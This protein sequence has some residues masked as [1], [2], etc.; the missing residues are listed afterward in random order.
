MGENNELLTSWLAWLRL[1]RSDP[2]RYDAL[3]AEEL[4]KGDLSVKQRAVLHGVR[5]RVDLEFDRVEEAIGRLKGVLGRL[6]SRGGVVLAELSALLAN[7]LTMADRCDEALEVLDRAATDPAA[8]AVGVLQLQRAAVY[9]RIGPMRSA[10]ACVDEALDVIGRSDP[11]LRARALNNRGIIRLYV[12]DLAA[13]RADFDEAEAIYRSDGQHAAAAEVAHN[14]AMVDAREGDLVAALAGFERAERELRTLGVPADAQAI[15]RAEILQAVGFYEEVLEELPA[16]VARLRATG[17]MADADEG[18]VYLAQAMY[19]TGQPEAATFLATTANALRRSNRGGWAAVLDDLALDIRLTSGETTG[20]VVAEAERIAVM[21]DHVGMNMFATRSWLRVAELALRVGDEATGRRAL[22]VVVG[23]TDS[24]VQRVLSFEARA[25]VSVLDGDVAAARSFT[26]QGLR[27]VD[28]LRSVM[29]ATDLRVQASAWGDGLA[30]LAVAIEADHGD[31]RDLLAAAERWRA[32]AAFVRPARRDDD[33]EIAGLLGELRSAN[34][35]VAIATAADREAARARVRAAEAAVTRATRIRSGGR[36]DDFGVRVEG[37]LASLTPGQMF[38]EFIEDRG[39]VSA[40]V[41][42]D[43]E[44]AVRQVGAV[45]TVRE[46]ARALHRTLRQLAHTSG[47]P[48][49]PLVAAGLRR[50]LANMRALMMAPLDGS[51]ADC[52]DLVIV[53]PPGLSALP[54]PVLAGVRVPISVA[55]SARLWLRAAVAPRRGNVVAIAGPGL[56]GALEEATSVAASYDDAHLCVGADATVDTV[57]GLLDAA[58]VAHV[59]AHARVRLSSPLFSS[60]QLFDGPATAHD[61]DR[62]RHAPQIMILSA[63]SSGLTAART[64]G[65]FLGLSTVLMAAGTSSLVAS[66]VPL[67]DAAAA[68]LLVDFH[69]ALVAGASVAEALLIAI[70]RLPDDATGA[71]LACALGCFGRGDIRLHADVSQVRTRV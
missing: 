22:Q 54:W 31:A 58:A 15:A 68:P 24:V 27:L 49:G 35:A 38:V 20:G 34:A 10:L 70:G 3:A 69:H 37:L 32:V 9:Y 43:G 33:P 8:L 29:H 56:P 62:L 60:V 28:R 45:E 25:R 2:L 16:V 17:M 64:D 42:R 30:R 40:V 53:P 5:A 47:T 48:A 63:C 67:P 6:D 44:V 14:R 36:I 71:L 11:V 39:T 18:A 4:A 21:L 50:Q 59:A 7:A 41:A 13:C 19:E 46:G 51:A 57:R 52:E 23:R 66:I 26:E 55:P 12:G 61:L 65:E 1:A